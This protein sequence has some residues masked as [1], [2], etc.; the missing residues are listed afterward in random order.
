MATQNSIISINTS[1]IENNEL[2]Q[3]TERCKLTVNYGAT[4]NATVNTINN[5]SNQFSIEMHYQTSVSVLFNNNEFNGNTYLYLVKPALNRYSV[6]VD[7]ELIVKHT[8]ATENLVMI[9]PIKQ[10]NASH[11]FF[12]TLFPKPSITKTSSN[13]NLENYSISKTSSALNLSN[14]V[15]NSSYHYY[16]GTSVLGF[17]AHNILFPVNVALGMS[18]KHLDLIPERNIS[19]YVPE[20]VELSYY[21]GISTNGDDNI[22][23]DCNPV[24]DNGNTIENKFDTSKVDVGKFMKNFSVIAGIVGGLFLVGMLYLIYKKSRSNVVQSI[25]VVAKKAKNV[26]VQITPK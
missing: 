22:Y 14:V 3:C 12:T 20:N 2:T 9:I 10:Q 13:L 19:T 26:A 25:G 4:P 5:S 15:P 6:N 23:I 11:S 18:K 8:G 16:Y 24:D 1:E 21:S 17:E 7:A